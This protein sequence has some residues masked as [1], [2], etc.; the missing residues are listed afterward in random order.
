MT[1]R[2]ARTA[3]YV[4]EG[5]YSSAHKNQ[6]DCKKVNALRKDQNHVQSQKQ[7]FLKQTAVQ[8]NVA[9]MT[10]LMI[11]EGDCSNGGSTESDDL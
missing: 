10:N 5:R 9:E 1:I 3:P 2:L 4:T 8:G 7:P 6:F 11:M